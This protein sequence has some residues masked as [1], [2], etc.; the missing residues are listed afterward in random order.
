VW[1]VWGKGEFVAKVLCVWG[2]GRISER[3]ITERK[4]EILAKST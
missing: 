2:W 4:Q 3:K 1:F